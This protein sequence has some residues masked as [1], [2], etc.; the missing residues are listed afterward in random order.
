MAADGFR[1]FPRDPAWMSAMVSLA[2]MIAE[3]EDAELAAQVY[4][5]LEPHADRCCFIGPVKIVPLR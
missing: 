3:V 4:D 2:D 1:M 5:L